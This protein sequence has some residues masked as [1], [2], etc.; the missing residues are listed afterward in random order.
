M[1][2]SAYIM[3]ALAVALIALSSCCK[4]HKPSRPGGKDKD[5][6]EE[7]SPWVDIGTVVDGKKV[8]WAKCNLGAENEWEYGDLYSWGELAPKSSYFPETQVYKDTPET[9]PLTADAANN[10][11]GGKWRMPTKADFEALL[12]LQNNEDYTFELMGVLKDGNGNDVWGLKITR[13]S[14]GKVLFFPAAG[15]S[16]GDSPSNVGSIGRYWTSNFYYTFNYP[17]SSVLGFTNG[18]A[19]TGSI[20][21]YM[22]LSIRPVCDE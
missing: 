12:A 15:D 20:R 14:T 2:S 22:G 16:Y 19:G 21:A 3:T 6:T 4:H 8:F 1:K 7:E 13:K 10:E 11:L 9:L 18:H 17:E 5:K